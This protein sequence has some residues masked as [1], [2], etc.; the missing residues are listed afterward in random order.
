MLQFDKIII[1]ATN[2]YFSLFNCFILNKWMG[3]TLYL[4]HRLIENTKLQADLANPHS[5]IEILSGTEHKQGTLNTGT[6]PLPGN[7]CAIFGCCGDIV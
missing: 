2:I 6:D 5:L 3:N 1:M 7:T 4:H